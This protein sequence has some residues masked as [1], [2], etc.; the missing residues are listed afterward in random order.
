MQ[1]LIHLWLSLASAA[2]ASPVVKRNACPTAAPAPIHLVAVNNVA[3]Q[4]PSFT[5]YPIA[6]SFPAEY[7]RAL[8]FYASTRAPY[9]D[10][11][12]FDYLGASLNILQTNHTQQYPANT[13]PP[14]TFDSTAPPAGSP[15][16]LQSGAPTNG[17]LT[18][19]CEAGYPAYFTID[20][21]GDFSWT[22]CAGSA[23]DPSI[24]RR[25]LYWRGTD[26]SCESVS[27][28]IA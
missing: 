3:P 2:V 14:V 10:T 18:Y 27:L 19:V 6:V 21:S 11:S 9:N 22:L 25:L 16:Q 15:L 4:D 7:N 26:P 8:Q 20:D 23:A 24:G 28:R 5:T 12:T 17:H 13:Q 1:R